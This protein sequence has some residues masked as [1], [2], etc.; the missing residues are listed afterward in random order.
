MLVINGVGKMRWYQTRAVVVSPIYSLRI[1]E[2]GD[3]AINLKK[4][5]NEA[6]IVRS[7]N[8]SRWRTVMIGYT[9]PVVIVGIQW[10]ESLFLNLKSSGG[11][12]SVY[13]N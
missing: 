1:I 13:G 2:A 4:R 12:I 11:W 7:T 10:V 5:A 9:R 3:I 8:S 6:L